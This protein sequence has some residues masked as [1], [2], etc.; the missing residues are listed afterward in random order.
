MNWESQ[1]TTVYFKEQVLRKRPYLKPEWCSGII[2]KELHKEIQ[3]D[4]R[5]RYWG[6]ISE[7]NKYLRVVTLKDKTLHNAFFDRN[8][9]EKTNN[10]I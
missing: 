3:E 8:F 1:K 5:I 4:G 9:K 10:E 6:Y 2:N 7:E